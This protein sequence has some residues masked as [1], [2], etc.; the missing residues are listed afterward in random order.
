MKQKHC[1]DKPSTENKQYHKV[2]M[3]SRE[4]K[5]CSSAIRL[6]PSD[7]DEGLQQ[8]QWPPPPPPPQ[9]QQQR[10]RRRRRRRLQGSWRSCQ[11]G[12]SPVVCRIVLECAETS[13]FQFLYRRRRFAVPVFRAVCSGFSHGRQTQ[14]SVANTV[15]AG[16][17]CQ[18]FVVCALH[19]LQFLFFVDVK[20]HCK[21]RRFACLSQL[22]PERSWGSRFL[23]FERP[24]QRPLTKSLVCLK[25]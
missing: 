16:R 2:A 24:L 10:R 21:H 13:C 20:K 23:L 9:Q 1:A 15:V 3:T 11:D 25:C 22:I 17:A 4:G 14:G 18:S 12:V 8:Q 19:V 7:A 6:H 5:N